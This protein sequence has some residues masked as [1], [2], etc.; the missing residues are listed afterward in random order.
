MKLKRIISLFLAVLMLFTVVIAEETVIEVPGILDEETQQTS[1]DIIVEEESSSQEAQEEVSQ[2]EQTYFSDVPS[3]SPYADAVNKMVESGII[4]GYGDNTFRPENGVTRAEMCKMINLTF[5]Y[6]EYDEAAGFPDVK[7]EDWFSPYVLSAQHYAYVEGYEDGTFRPNNNI[8]RQ[9]VCMIINRIVK[10]ADLTLFGFEVDISDEVSDWAREAVEIIVS[11]N[12][13]PLEENNS[14]RAKEN[15]KR[16]ELAALLANFVVPPA[17]PLT[18]VVEFY[19]SEGNLVCEADTVYIGDYPTVPE[20]PA[21]KDPGYEFVGWRVVGTTEII[22]AK[23]HIIIGN[24]KYESVYALK[25][26]EVEFYNGGQLFETQIVE[27]GSSPVEPLETPELGGYEFV[28]WSIYDDGVVVDV[29]GLVIEKKTSLFATFEKTNNDDSEENVFYNVFFYFEEEIYDT[30]SILKGTS[31]QLPVPPKSEDGDFIGWSLNEYGD[32]DD[33]IDV[34][35]YIVT[36]PVDFYAI[37]MKNPNDP[38]F[39]EKMSR[40]ITQLED[41]TFLTVNGKYIDA[42]Y[43]I[44]DCMTL[45][46]NDANSGIYVDKAYV[47][48]VYEAQIDYV[49]TLVLDEMSGREASEFKTL[50]TNNVDKDVRDFLYEYF[51]SGEDLPI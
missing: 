13:M 4:D 2:Q 51:L 9:E 41:A 33:V 20:A 38:A 18:A 19:D 49:E 27:H 21:H 22:D 6:V 17:E 31:P 50:L 39:I 46:L 10:P 7:E 45:V 28:G 30:Q 35:T 1:E 16:Y 8:T 24:T 34:T 40:G 14:F 44:V 23:S 15:I 5:N 29:T 3:D 11:N 26:Y 32:K 48:R 12:L 42:I 47:G 37:V 43:A 25:K 36:S